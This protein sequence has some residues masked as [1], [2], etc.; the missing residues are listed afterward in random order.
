MERRDNVAEKPRN[1]LARFFDKFLSP[2][3]SV[4]R[5]WIYITFTAL[6][7]L[8]IILQMYAPLCAFEYGGTT[9][10]V[11]PSGAMESL[12]AYGTPMY[13]FAYLQLAVLAILVVS[14]LIVIY[15]IARNLFAWRREEK[16]AKRAK[17]TVIFSV[18]VTGA[19][20]IFSYLFSPINLALG[21][22]S[23][24]AVNPAPLIYSVIVM[25][26]YALFSG[27]IGLFREQKEDETLLA[28]RDR[29][30]RAEQL[31]A[32]RGHKI[33][34]LIYVLLNSIFSVIALMS[35]FMTVTFDPLN[36]TTIPDYSLSGKYLLF[37]AEVAALTPGERFVSYFVFVMFVLTLAAAFLSLIAC[38]SRSRLYG[39]V[40]IGTVGLSS[41]VCLFVGL[42]GQYYRIVQELNIEVI[43]RILTERYASMGGMLESL[44]E[45]V[46]YTV[47][48]SS[49]WFFIGGLAVIVVMLF[50][51]PFTKITALEQA[52]AAEDAARRPQT[53]E[54]T[55]RS[56]DAS[57]TEDDNLDGLD[58]ANVPA[59]SALVKFDPC[60]A[61]TQLDRKLP[62]YRA[63]LSEKQQA[64]F[65]DPTLPKLV[66]FIVQ[67][68]R[69]SRHHLFYT[70]EHIAAFL[71][72]L[73]TTKLSIL[74]GMSGT[75][76]TSLPKIVAE[77]LMSV[78]DIVE[79]ESSWRDKNELL[80]YYNEFNKIYTP[81]KFTQALYSARLNPD[82][83]TFIVLDEM[84]LSRIEYYFSDFLSLMENEPDKREL[85]L[86]N[87]PLAR[88]EEG[89]AA[90]YLGLSEGHTLKIPNNVWFVGTA[91]RDESTYDI[92]DKVYDRAH[93]MNFDKRA[94]KV[95]YY[96]DPIPARY[97][98]ATELDRLFK[99]AKERVKFSLDQ[100]PVI[101]EV[102]KLL[103]PYNIS[104]GNRV[105]LQ[106]ESFVSIYASCFTA[107]DAVIWDALETILLSKVVRK[108]E[109]K[110]VEDKETLADE[111]AKLKL[112]RCSAFIRS[113][114]E[115]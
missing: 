23:Y 37:E 58:G 97:L 47:H 40:A 89:G 72:G 78:C 79:V 85:K 53:V 106:M 51:R 115:D 12:L 107:N 14:L 73:G 112:S 67:Y 105:A 87:V 98:S 69:D 75:G 80:G 41:A 99:E 81:K 28:K 33:E 84:N 20:T 77:A 11:K 52:I 96:N 42:F 22:M 103:E 3:L 108:L 34:L 27:V 13:S 56:F 43:T 29:E 57:T 1:G 113:L 63:A 46:T 18:V 111:F 90:D 26:L 64:L 49:M 93:T 15:R 59:P 17:G 68:A 36:G 94:A 71:A 109:L 32:L 2:E 83:L 24:S 70:P 86:L 50:R 95:Q 19:L 8:G 92:S 74:Q 31:R 102:E 38:L 62:A 7:I 110:S 65:E 9:F 48:S 66:D 5:K 88:V 82:T 100:Y 21:G 60:P 55:S 44:L 39:K 4:L 16:M 30:H 114:K 6:P 54:I 61:F 45:E 25:I 101:A 104:F 35:T 91:N 76:K 10:L